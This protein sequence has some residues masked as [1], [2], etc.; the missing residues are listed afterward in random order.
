M[1]LLPTTP[2]SVNAVAIDQNTGR[3]RRFRVPLITIIYLRYGTLFASAFLSELSQGIIQSDV[4]RI[5]FLEYVIPRNK[6]KTRS[7]FGF[8]FR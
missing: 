2:Y 8:R 1:C 4:L 5:A 7:I 3:V 6:I